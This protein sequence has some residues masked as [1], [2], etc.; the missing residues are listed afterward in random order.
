MNPL[1]SERAQQYW[2]AAVTTFTIHLHLKG[3][4]RSAPIT[5]HCKVLRSS[6]LSYSAS[7]EMLFLMVSFFCWGQDFGQ[8]PWTIGL[9]SPWFDFSES[10]K[11]LRKVCHFEGNEKR[12]LMAL[13]SAA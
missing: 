4:N 12:N 13:V 8:K 6:K 10:K 3:A 5:P 1:D 7:L 11:V 9:Y 2:Y